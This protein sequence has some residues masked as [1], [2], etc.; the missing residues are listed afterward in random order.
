MI[1]EKYLKNTISTIF[2]LL[3]LLIFWIEYLPPNIEIL[4]LLIIG[5][6]FYFFSS[7]EY[8]LTL[9]TILCFS[10]DWLTYDTG[11][12]PSKLILSIDLMII[13]LFVNTIS[14]KKNIYKVELFDIIFFLIVIIW[15][16]S[17]YINNIVIVNGILSFR[18]Y[19]RFIVIYYLIRCY[20]ISEKVLI[21]QI[22]LIFIISLFQLPIVI[23]QSLSGKT[24]DLRSGSFGYHQTGVMA[25]F[26]SGVILLIL[27]Y[28]EITQKRRL[29]LLTILF[30]IPSIIN[31][32][33]VIFYLVLYSILYIVL[34]KKSIKSI[35]NYSILMI[36][37]INIIITGIKMITSTNLIDDLIYN[38]NNIVES[39]AKERK[40][41]LG[42]IGALKWSSNEINKNINLLLFGYGPGVYRGSFLNNDYYSDYLFL[43][44]NKKYITGYGYSSF[45][46]QWGYLGLIMFI[47]MIISLLKG[48][49]KSTRIKDIVPLMKAIY[50]GFPG[51]TILFI[52]ANIYTL[53]WESITFGYTFWLISGIVYRLEKGTILYENT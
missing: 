13:L 52:M 32:A 21:K 43:E 48:Y 49:K 5:I 46:Y 14:T 34:H 11:I 25:V 28:S 23:I 18:D 6:L 1:Q 7:I 16:I 4:L 35:I 12:L 26:M 19:C 39:Q 15:G 37:L 38:F 24:F 40:E 53:L 36:L 3:L 22:K 47:I 31:S 33:N 30:I 45:I 51:I 10:I 27:L 20:S 44:L 17:V 2:L 8:K 9:L 29:L 42:R 50:L 41:K